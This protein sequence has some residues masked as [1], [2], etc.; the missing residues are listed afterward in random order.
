[1]TNWTQYLSEHSGTKIT[2]DPRIVVIGSGVSGVCMGA[3]LVDAGVQSFV[4]LE[5]A[6]SVGGTWRENRYPGAG[7]D[8]N[9]HYYSYTFRRNPG[10]TRSSSPSAEI[11]SYLDDVVDEWGLRSHLRFGKQVVSTVYDDGEWRV[12]TADGAVEVADIVIS[13]S[14]FLHVPQIP[15]FEGMNEFQ[16][17]VFHSARWPQDLELEGARIANIGNGS[18]SAQIVPA[19][20]DAVE[21]LTVFQRTAQWILPVENEEYT[22]EQRDAFRNDPSL[23]EALYEEKQLELHS[24]FGHAVLN[25]QEPLDALKAVCVEYLDSVKDPVLR[26]KLEPPYEFMCKR[27]I[28]SSG[29]Y[30]ALQ[31]PNAELVTEGIE[32]FTASGILTTDGVHREFDVIV[33]STG[34]K[35]HEWCRPL[36][37]VGADGVTLE[38]AW[39]GGA[40]S[41]K[42]TS[43][44]GF[45]NFFMVG[46]PHSPLGNTSFM[47]ASEIQATNIVRL[48]KLREE[49]GATT[50]AP[51]PEAQAQFV[52]YMQKRAEGTVWTSG[53]VSWYFD[54]NGRLDMWTDTPE[55]FADMFSG[56]PH[57]E[58]YVLETASAPVS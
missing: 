7:C 44:A 24:G 39:S 42:S 4:I 48:L 2:G 12:T 57:A 35:A 51:R 53:C 31:H 38:E 54:E 36:G 6:A 13:C 18:S 22:P 14:G 15:H 5:K 21:Q 49:A 47:A 17:R 56:G 40:T 8:L 32:R 9:S 41:F 50:I 10:F 43:L 29:Y 3:K 28:M 27:L 19:I 30:E 26:A 45:P 34:F 16:G 46:G 23:L 58:D 20:V 52:D 1:M 25:E 11:N 33:L 37:V 55:N